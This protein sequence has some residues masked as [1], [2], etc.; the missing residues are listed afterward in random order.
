[1]FSRS[2]LIVLLGLSAIHGRA[3]TFSGASAL[4]FTRHAVSFGARPSGSPAIIRL[5]SYIE[6][7]ARSH[8]WQ[9]SEDSFTAQTPNGPVAMKN[10]IAHL[11]GHSSQAIV[12]TGHYDTKVMPGFVG[13][14]DGG[15]STGFLLELARVLPSED[16]KADLYLVWFDGEEAVKQWTDTDSLYGSRHLAAKWAA[17]GTNARIKAM[18]NIDMIGDKDL[19]IVRDGNSSSPVVNLVWKAAESLGYAKYFHQNEGGIEDDHIPFMNAQV[20]AVDIIDFNYG[21]GNSY[22]HTSQ[23]TMDKL[24]AHSFEVVGAVMLEVR[25]ELDAAGN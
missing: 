23:D 7:Q 14:N 11:P 16:R 15:S 22:W 2:A 17:D 8:G 25:R 3:A 6:A 13:A 21:P 20:R 24:G 4:E 19:D 12:F 10:V 18:V 5:R 9:V 1:M